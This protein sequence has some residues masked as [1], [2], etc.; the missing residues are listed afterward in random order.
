MRKKSAFLL[1]KTLIVIR[2]YKFGIYE[3]S[4]FSKL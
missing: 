4:Q 1:M 3:L 2:F